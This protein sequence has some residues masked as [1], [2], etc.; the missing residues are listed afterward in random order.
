MIK[1]HSIECAPTYSYRVYV[2][3]GGLPLRVNRIMTL[4]RLH[5]ETLML[6]WVGQ[7]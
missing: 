6:Q 1:A 4:G 7:W 5:C 3:K 2:E